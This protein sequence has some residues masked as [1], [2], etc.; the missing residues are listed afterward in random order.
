MQLQ[1]RRDDILA[2]RLVE[3]RPPEPQEGQVLL[4]VDRFGYSANNV[5]YAAAGETLGYWRFFPTGEAAWGMVPVWGFADVEASRVEGIEA[6]ERIFG[7]LPPAGHLNVE[8]VRVSTEQFMDG[9]GHRAELPAG[10]NIYRRVE[11]ASEDAEAR[12][13]LLYPLYV[14]SWCLADALERAD[15]FGAERI[16]VASASSK[17]AIGLAFAL[18]RHG[19]RV[20]VVG[21]T[22]PRNTAFVRDLALY[23]E[24]LTYDALGA[25]DPDIPTTIVD[26][27]GDAAMLGRLHA[28]LGEAMRQTL[29]VGL[30]HWEA[31]RRDDRRDRERSTFFFAPA[32]I[33]ERIREWGA[34]EFAARTTTFMDEAIEDSRRWMTLE[35]IAG[36]EPLAEVHRE[37]ARNESDA[38]KGFV[39]TP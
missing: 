26:M 24:V 20:P 13:M 17:T 3:T 25:L 2:T 38:A 9:A 37:I 32:H 35:P 5:T 28:H 21:L 14:T 29:D 30:T 11:K 6:G 39:V 16:V 23:D 12:H 22:S 31:P 18:S 1:T 19:S 7:Y 4:R 10:Y 15:R 33:Q 34:A 8:P 27:S 36:L